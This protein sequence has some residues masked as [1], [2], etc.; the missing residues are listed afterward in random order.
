MDP[1]VTAS[2]PGLVCLRHHTI[3]RQVSNHIYHAVVVS[4]F[5][6]LGGGDDQRE[7]VTSVRR[8]DVMMSP[9]AAYTEM[10][11]SIEAC[12]LSTVSQSCISGVH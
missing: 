6:L 7:R 5:A 11:I 2:P 9:V 12:G 1:G 10:W 8:L 4:F 3:Y